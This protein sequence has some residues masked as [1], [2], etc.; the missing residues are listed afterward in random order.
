MSA[1]MLLGT[2][3]AVFSIGPM[4]CSAQSANLAKG[5]P[6]SLTP[7]PNYALTTDAN[8]DVQLTDGTY[9][10][11]TIWTRA[12]TVGWSNAAPVTIVVDLQS[13]QPIAGVSYSTAAGIA[14]V[15]WP[16]SIFVLTSDDGHRYWPVADLAV[17][18]GGEAGPPESGYSTFRFS[19]RDL[20]THGRYVAIVVDQNGPY[21]FCD[22]IEILAGDSSWL[23]SPPTGESTTDLQKFFVTAHMRFSIQSR[24]SSDLRDARTA[25]ATS[26]VTDILR[27]QLASSLDQAEHEIADIPTPDPDTFTTI[28]PLNDLHARIMSV[29]GAIAHAEGFPPLSAWA[30]NPWDFVRPLDKPPVS[31]EPGTVRIAAM[32]G[33]TRAGAI[34]VSNSTEQA[35]TVSLQVTEPVEWTSVPDV[36]LYEVKWTDTR[37]LIPVADALIPLPASG[38]TFEVPAGMTRQVWVKFKPQNRS[39]GSYRGFLEARVGDALSAHVPFE[40]SVLDATFPDRPSLH[41]G[42][43][44][45]TDRQNILGLTPGN[46][47]AFI[48]QLHALNVDAPWATSGVMPSGAFDALGRLIQLPDTSSFDRWVA[49]WP[50]AN[51]YYVFVSANGALGSVPT[52][53]TARFTTAAGQWITFWV[54]HAGQQGVQP[55]QLMLLLVDEPYTAAQDDQIVT[56]AT[57]IKAAQ[58]DVGIW[59]DPGFKN[60]ASAS[61]R[62]LDVADVVALKRSLMLQQ[63]A[64]FVEFYQGW[65]TGVRALSVY[66][67]SGPARLLDPY[68]YYRLQAWVCA[69]LGA[70]SSFFWSFADDAGGASWNEYR[71]VQTPYSPFF[72]SSDRVTITKHSEAIR[73]GI[74]DFEY[75]TMLR[76]Q[77][78]VIAQ[79][80]PNHPALSGARK[81]LEHAVD[82]VLQTPGA[83]DLQWVS[84]KDRSAAESTRLMIAD[85]LRLLV[86]DTTPPVIGAA[87]N[88]ITE[89]TGQAGAA[90]TYV[91]PTSSDAVDGNGIA[92]CSPASETTF[93]LGA[94]TVTCSARDTAGNAS[95]VSFTVTVRDTTP[96]VIDAIAD[97]VTEATSEANT[98][99]TYPAPS[100]SDVVDGTGTATCEPGSG[101]AFTLGQTIVK[102]SAF[103]GAGNSSSRWFSVIVRDTTAPILTLPSSVLVGAIAATGASASYDAT[104]A[105]AV[106]GTNTVTCFPASG[107]LFPMGSTTVICGSTDRHANTRTG[108]FTVTVFN[109]PPVAQPDA[110]LTAENAPVQISVLAND[111]DIDGGVLTLVGVGAAAHGTATAG[112]GGTI[113]YVPANG[114]VGTE[115]FTY[116]L[117]DGQGG[118]ATATVT[119]KVSRRRRFVAH[120]VERAP[121]RPAPPKQR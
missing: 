64:P 82:T 22:E 93:S 77:V 58:P 73:E 94:T 1:V 48:D 91:S 62:L 54:A 65:A 20:R 97:I 95:S 38:A 83:T 5:R 16:R 55:S 46:A 7:R 14:G 15:Q 117:N 99:V 103:D 112:A 76:H 25:L 116:T 29:Q 47:G 68:T 43:W 49:N 9:S 105:D 63:G 72:L 32:N 90:V 12:S 89:A 35:M 118:T 4:P 45:Y 61:P 59:E 24:L 85:A 106:D 17:I 27:V 60:P 34:N 11:S 70:T 102:C 74:E 109:H 51:R 120:R 66:G 21:T 57:A 6:Y 19:T 36:H 80:D 81:L 10:T 84:S 26:H 101:R 2:L 110:A 18:R 37:E 113:N 121:H 111:S 78:A 108:S 41:L 114:Y 33:E 53:S 44:D 30:V 100:T 79:S 115:R 31:I 69:S 107:S 87:S 8:D 42:G 71:S 28:L 96:P 67:A 119:V 86:R 39:P 88:I 3:A 40:L 98:V 23:T 75:V 92:T 56:W 52:T 104:A 50:N 13:I